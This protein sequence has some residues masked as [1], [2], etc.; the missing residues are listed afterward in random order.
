MICLSKGLLA[1]YS[2]DNGSVITTGSKIFALK[3]E[4]SEL[5]NRSNGRFIT[6]ASTDE[7]ETAKKLSSYGLCA[8]SPGYSESDKLKLLF[9]CIPVLSPFEK[10]EDIP[11]EILK[12]VKS[13]AF[14]IAEIIRL[15]QCNISYDSMSDKN[16][17]QDMI[18]CVYA[19]G[20]SP[21]NIDSV[22]ELVVSQPYQFIVNDIL[23]LILSKTIFLL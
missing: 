20:A 5:W 11:S 23:S 2:E 22:V 15:V 6:L 17:F 19:N 8:L 18:G 21:G 4:C 10:N 3:N 1:E 9:S 16:G 14:D 7:I 13:E 12:F